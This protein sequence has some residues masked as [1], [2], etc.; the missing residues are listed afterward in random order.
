MRD[1]GAEITAWYICER[2][3][4]TDSRKERKKK[5]RDQEGNE[6][7]WWRDVKEGIYIYMI[8]IVDYHLCMFLYICGKDETQGYVFSVR[9]RYTERIRQ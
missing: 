9:S 6:T 8:L 4:D 1:A 3:N 7:K 2:E 5:K